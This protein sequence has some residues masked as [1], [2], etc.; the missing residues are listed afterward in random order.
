MRNHELCEKLEDKC[1][2]IF[3]LLIK[4]FI[5]LKKNSSP[6]QSQIT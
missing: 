2:F 1:Y 3:L 4:P 6:N 5:L